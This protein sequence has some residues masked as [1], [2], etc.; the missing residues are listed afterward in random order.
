VTDGDPVLTAQALS[1]LILV[2]SHRA[3]SVSVVGDCAGAPGRVGE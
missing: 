1:A 2:M 3:V